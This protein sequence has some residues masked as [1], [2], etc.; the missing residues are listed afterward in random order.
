[1]ARDFDSFGL[2]SNPSEILFLSLSPGKSF[3]STNVGAHN[4]GLDTAHFGYFLG[5]GY[6]VFELS[7]A[8][9]Y[10]WACLYCD[11]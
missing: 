3:L 8:I 4:I 1:M 10:L 7:W 5:S 6:V 9:S 11:E 2:G